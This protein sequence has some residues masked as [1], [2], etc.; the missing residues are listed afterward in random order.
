VF[1]RNDEYIRMAVTEGHKT[2]QS[3]SRLANSKHY[4]LNMTIMLSQV[5]FCKYCLTLNKL[6]FKAIYPKNRSR[7]GLRSFL[8]ESN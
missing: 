7:Q 8:P 6:S 2:G 3:L 5:K 4:L 1:S